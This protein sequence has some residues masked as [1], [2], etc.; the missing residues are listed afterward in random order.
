MFYQT[1]YKHEVVKYLLD[2]GI[3]ATIAKYNIPK[4]TIYN[5]ASV[6]RT[7][8]LDSQNIGTNKV[9]ERMV[10]FIGK[11]KRLFPNIGRGKMKT[12][13]DK[14]SFINNTDEISMSSIGRFL[15]KLKNS[16]EE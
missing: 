12:L 1:Q 7:G 16:T 10:T 3:K 6:Q 4:S 9:D 14:F 13:C 15:A 2:A 11:I 5:W 8:N